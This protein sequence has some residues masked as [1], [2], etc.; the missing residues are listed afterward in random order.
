MMGADGGWTGT[1]PMDHRTKN[2][3][4]LL[5]CFSASP[6]EIYTGMI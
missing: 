6:I 3:N 4:C 5:V 1:D 2:L